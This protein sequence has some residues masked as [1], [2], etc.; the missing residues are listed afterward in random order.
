MSNR[1]LSAL[2]QQ[3]RQFSSVRAL[4]EA[5]RDEARLNVRLPSV[6][7]VTAYLEGAGAALL[8]K[9]E[10]T[11]PVS[12]S[13]AQLAAL[14]VLA[15]VLLDVRPGQSLLCCQSR[16]RSVVGSQV[17]CDQWAAAARTQATSGCRV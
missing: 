17:S 13:D 2:H 1:C 3:G 16:Y 14:C 9:T 7:A 15:H 10:T 4:V 12:V 6:R 5:V 11:Q 8:R